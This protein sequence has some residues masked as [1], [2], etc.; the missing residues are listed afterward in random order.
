MRIHGIAED[1]NETNDQ[2]VNKIEEC[3]KLVD[4]PFNKDCIDRV[5]RVGKSYLDKSNG[6][7]VKSII[8]KYKA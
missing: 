1:K 3:Y 5:H 7:S 8:V 4:L 6:K 2:V